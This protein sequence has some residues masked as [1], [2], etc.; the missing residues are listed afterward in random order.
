MVCY[1]LRKSRYYKHIRFL[2]TRIKKAKTTSKRDVIAKL[3]K[4]VHKCKTFSRRVVAQQ[5]K[6]T[7]AI[8]SCK[9]PM[10]YNSYK[11]NRDF[12]IALYLHNNKQMIANLM[13]KLKLNERTCLF[14][15]HMPFLYF[16]TS[17]DTLPISNKVPTEGLLKLNHFQ[18]QV[19]SKK[20]KKQATKQQKEETSTTQQHKTTDTSEELNCNE[21]VTK[22][23]FVPAIPSSKSNLMS[24]KSKIVPENSEVVPAFPTEIRSKF[25][26]LERI[27]S[28]FRIDQEQTFTIT[29]LPFLLNMNDVTYF[30][31]T[32]SRDF[33]EKCGKQVTKYQEFLSR[34]TT[35][36]E[37]T[38]NNAIKTPQFLTKSPAN[39][40]GAYKAAQLQNLATL[41]SN[42][43]SRGGE[44]T[45]S[46][47]NNS[48]W[49]KLSGLATF[50][51]VFARI[52]RTLPV[53]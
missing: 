39:L 34:N 7:Q 14:G 15:T 49:V 53:L 51:V 44:S 19:E 43:K 27:F 46:E 35:T 38:A 29:K 6:P 32:T 11:K 2:V 22:D 31:Q 45:Q 8:I 20:A 48:T 28:T 24:D 18:P 5:K 33:R 16:I 42:K 21:D 9:S 37:E 4:N 26:Y 50:G 1:L 25:S 47:N 12:M 52:I 13:K 40:C 17:L 36:T 3:N 23:L 41:W 30:V 10:K